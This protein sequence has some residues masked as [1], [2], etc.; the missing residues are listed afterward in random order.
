MGRQE[1]SS[2][3]ASGLLHDVERIVVDAH[4]TLHLERGS[5]WSPPDAYRW[6]RY[7]N[8]EPVARLLQGL[9]RLRREGAKV[10]AEAVDKAC[11]KAAKVGF[12]N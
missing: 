4:R 1:F 2:L 5:P 11:V 9:Q 10:D 3:V 12:S 8:P 7:E 6:L